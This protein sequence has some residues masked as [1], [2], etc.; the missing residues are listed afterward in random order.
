MARTLTLTA[1]M[2]WPIEDGKQAAKADFNISLAYTTAMHIEKPYAG[3][4]TDEALDLPAS[5]I[6]FLLLQSVGTEDIE[7]KLN[8]NSNALTLKAGD[9]YILV[10]NPDG[11]ITAVTVTVG[12]APATLKGYAFA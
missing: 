2:S 11:D 7:V 12:T 4:V 6:K 8:G 3:T 10:Y 1:E 9:G 5:S